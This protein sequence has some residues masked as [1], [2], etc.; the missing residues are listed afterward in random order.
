MLIGLYEYKV[1]CFRIAR[2]ELLLQIST[3]MLIF[4]KRVNVTLVVLNLGVGESGDI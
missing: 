1:D 4:A 2:L 3:S